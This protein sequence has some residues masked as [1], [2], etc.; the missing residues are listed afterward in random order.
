MKLCSFIQNL[1]L[2]NLP[3]AEVRIRVVNRDVPVF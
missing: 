1:K 3:F 2:N